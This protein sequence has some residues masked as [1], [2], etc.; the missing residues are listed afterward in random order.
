M[1]SNK[2][3]LLNFAKNIKN[4]N[5]T[6]LFNQRNH[7]LKKENVNEI[8]HGDSDCQKVF[9]TTQYGTLL[10]KQEEI[11]MSRNTANRLK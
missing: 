11:P 8:Q 2:N 9:G 4:I 7:P 3:S 1:T 10:T 6:V 5:H